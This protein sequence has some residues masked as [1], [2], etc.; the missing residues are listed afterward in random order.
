MIGRLSNVYDASVAGGLGGLLDRLDQV[1][2]QAH[3]PHHTLETAAHR[4][5]PRSAGQ[6]V[7]VMAPMG[8]TRSQFTWV[9]T[10]WPGP[11]DTGRAPIAPHYCGGNNSATG[12]RARVARVRAEY[13]G[14]L[15]SSGFWQSEKDA[16]VKRNTLP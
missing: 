15:D 3:S 10:D 7:S 5:S 2:V 4:H 9:T 13:P 11:L 12:T 8:G 6:H 16:L 1:R 14:Q